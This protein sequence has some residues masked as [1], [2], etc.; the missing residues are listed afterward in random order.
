M[1]LTMIEGDVRREIENQLEKWGVQSHPDGTGP[2]VQL[3]LGS[4]TAQELADKA[5]A[6]CQAAAQDGNTTWLLIALEEILEAAAEDDPRALYAELI[7][8]AAV[9]QNWAARILHRLVR[10]GD[11]R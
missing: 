1:R 8:V 6:A 3:D 4:G 5:R 2:D 11:D 10:E 7:Q 9:A